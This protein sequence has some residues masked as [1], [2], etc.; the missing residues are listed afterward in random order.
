MSVAL[1]LLKLAAVG[2]VAAMFASIFANRDHRQRKWWEM[3]VAAYQTS[4]ESL[5][6]L[7]YFYT[8]HFAAEISDLPIRHDRQEQLA[9][10]WNES[11]QKVRRFSD[12]GAFLFSE[13]AN[14]ALR[15]FLK[16]AHGHSTFEQ[17]NSNIDL[18]EACLRE[19]IECSQTDL[20]L[21]EGFLERFG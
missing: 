10:S 9:A 1:E 19:M 3:R 2:L 14:L 15:N 8:Q 20:K 13:R 5:S 12:S 17:L 6:D 18:A 4:I 16:H 7:A 11:L 21:K